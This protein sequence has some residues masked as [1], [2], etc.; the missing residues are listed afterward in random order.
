MPELQHLSYSS[1]TA[2]LEC[3]H[4]WKLRYVDGL[5]T[6]ATPS[7]VL[8]SA[9][10]GTIA[11]VLLER[12]GGVI[13]PDVQSIWSE[14]WTKATQQEVDWGGD[15]E[16]EVSNTGV[17]LLMHA[18]ATGVLLKLEPMVDDQGPFIE[19]KIELR[20][21]GVTI[22]VIGYVDLVS[23]DGLI[24][25]FKTAARA[26]SAGQA[27]QESQP[28][29]YLAALNQAGVQHT[30]GRF[31]HIVMVKTRTPQVQVINSTR[32]QS[33][34][35]WMFLVVAEVWKGI[36]G[37]VFP[38]NPRS[39]FNYGRKCEFFDRCRGRQS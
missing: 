36:S 20:V 13:V 1:I 18:G 2:Y 27:E 19:R 23:S 7:L 16:Q 8:G 35:L 39:C 28:L 15:L 6:P 17:K 9:V 30:P 14:E 33:D 4:K 32:H 31:V 22:P 24:H 11:R 12:L 5:K 10:H 37:G 25:D 38:R 29:F 26:W 34:M 3:A 21:P